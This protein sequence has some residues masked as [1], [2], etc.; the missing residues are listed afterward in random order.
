MKKVLLM[1]LTAALFPRLLVALEVD[2]EDLT[3]KQWYGLYLGGEKAGYASNELVVE[4]DGAIVVT[5]DARFAITMAGIRQDMRVFSQRVY[6]PEGEL[7]RI[8]SQVTDISGTNTFEAEVSGDVMTLR[9]SVGGDV[10]VREL[11]APSESLADALKQHRLVTGE[12]KVG[13]QITFTMFEPMQ[14]QEIEGVS[15]IAGVEE[16]MLHGAETKVY[17]VET[18]LDMSTADTPINMESVAYITEDGKTLEDQMS[19]ITMRLEPEELARDVDYAND[20]IISNA[21]MVD[22]PIEDPRT[23]ERL[24][25]YIEGPL[26]EEHLYNDARQTI[27]KVEDGRYRFEAR[28]TGP[29]DISPPERPIEDEAA[30]RWLEATRFVQSDN[31]RIIAQ[32]EEIVGDETDALKAV[33]KI[34]DWVYGNMRTSFSAQL[35]NALDVLDSMEG[36]CTEYSVLFVALCRAAGIPAREVGGLIY[37]DTPEPGFYFHQ[38]AKVWLGEWVDVDPTFGQVFAD[39]THIKLSEGDIFEQTML[40][41]V[42]GQI[43]V[44]VAEEEEDAA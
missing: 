18:S 43:E 3:G 39:A 32:A 24:T 29:D 15:R 20:V 6:G 38:W 1:I 23:R 31:E 25:L 9:S 33:E 4:E 19:L 21:A 11:P 17:R 2:L 44:E 22:A 35:S 26:S 37:V 36:D 27:E 16:R 7:R 10:Q 8:E 14:E 34:T 41:P 42:I 12:A 30:A 40:L 5:E 28:L 13:D